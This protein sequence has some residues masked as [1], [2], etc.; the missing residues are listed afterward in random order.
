MAKRGRFS[1]GAGYGGVPQQIINQ[2]RQQAA[3]ENTSNTDE[4]I[5]P[6][7]GDAETAPSTPA[8]KE[9]KP[10]TA[11]QIAANPLFS[12]KLSVDQA[13][14]NYIKSKQALNLMPREGATGKK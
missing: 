12:G 14:I 2:I 1:G 8:A 7:T 13:K 11:E 5:K 4:T 6:N 9:R 3:G 10:L